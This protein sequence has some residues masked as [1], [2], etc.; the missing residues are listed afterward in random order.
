VNLAVSVPALL[1]KHP[2]VRAVR[3]TGSRA[4]GRVHDLSDWD[5]VVETDNFDHVAEGLPVLVGPLQPLAQQ[6]DPYASHACYMLILRGPAKIDFLFLDEHRDW[7]P[8]WHAS[9]ET[10]EAIDCHFWDWI[11]WLEQKRRG[12]QADFVAT[13]LEDMHELMLAPIGAGSRPGS[14]P[15]AISAYLD[16]RDALEQKFGLRV[17][18]ELEQEVHPAVLRSQLFADVRR[19]GPPGDEPA[20]GP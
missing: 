6:W 18:R 7:S 11:L 8:P 4:S 3:L 5:F 9:P 12:G 15:M 14:I 1:L 10:L 19:D 13:G 16:A 20:S 17:P 2:N